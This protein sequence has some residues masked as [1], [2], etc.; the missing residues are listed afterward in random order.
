MP[1]HLLIS[2]TFLQPTC[3]ARLGKEDSAP[4]EWPPS[5]LRLF[6]AM[7][8][9]AAA[10]WASGD[11]VGRVSPMASGPLAAFRWL[12][13][14]CEVRPP[15]ILAPRAVSGQA[16]PRWVPNNSTDVV[17]A[18]WARRQSGDAL[19]S[20]E[21]RTKKVFRPTH[22]LDGSSV[23]YLWELDESQVTEARLHSPAVIAAAR[24]IVAIGWGIDVAVGDARLVDD[25]EVAVLRGERWVPG[26]THAGGTPGLRLPVSGTLDA[27][28]RRNAA[29]LNRLKDG[30]FHPVPPLW[31]FRTAAYRRANDLP[32]R[33]FAAFLLRTPGSDSEVAAFPATRAVCVAAMVRHAACEAAKSDLEAAG[34]R[35]PQWAEQFVAGHGP[36]QQNGRVIADSWPRFSYMPLPSIGHA[37]AGGLIRRVLIAEPFFGRGG[38]GQSARWAAQRLAGAELIN[39][40][41][42]Q[43]VARLEPI[44][45]DESDFAT[46]FR[47]YAARTSSE[48][49]TGWTSVTPVILHGYD[50]G[51]PAKRDRLL[52]DCLCFAGIDPGAIASIESRPSSWDPA[53]TAPL[54]AFKRPRY[55]EH[56]PAFH[57]RVQLRA[58]VAGPLSLG[59]GRHCGLGVMAIGSAK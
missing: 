47:H 9:G 8:A 3:H 52:R 49:A 55:L 46:V 2:I 4:N 19:V 5:P 25:A 48:A 37:N 18:K 22:L 6:Q 44:E 40:D 32:H 41:T 24:C 51:K 35:S 10:R 58:P 13:A 30:V 36:R 20:F 54:R 38:D 33:H 15:T 26:Q 57:V 14:L 29:F 59:A 1:A 17:A 7:V 43:P 28:E 53:A 50:D 45:P 39:R 34:W 12:E 42:K 27:L 11:G 31:A 23:H 21:D 56:L 16:V